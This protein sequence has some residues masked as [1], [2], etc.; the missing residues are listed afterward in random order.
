M[1]AEPDLGWLRLPLWPNASTVAPGDDRWSAGD[2]CRS[3]YGS[4]LV[5]SRRHPDCQRQEYFDINDATPLCAVK[6]GQFRVTMGFLIPIRLNL[7][8]KKRS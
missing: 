2:S 8:P 1:E 5:P 6:H 3:H 7:C 4:R